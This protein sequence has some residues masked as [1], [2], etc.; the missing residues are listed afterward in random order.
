[1]KYG[2]LVPSVIRSRYNVTLGTPN[3][4][5]Y[6]NTQAVFE[7]LNSYSP[8]DLQK[9]FDKLSPTLKGAN[10]EQIGLIFV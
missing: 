5:Q 1:M 10:N 4:S 7:V 8:N 2:V 9:F 6:N 3:F